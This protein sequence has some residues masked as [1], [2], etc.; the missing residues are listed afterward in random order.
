MTHDESISTSVSSTGSEPSIEALSDVELVRRI[1]GGCQESLLHL[2]VDRCG[3][4]LRAIA[5]RCHYDGDLAHD[6]C[7]HLFGQAGDWAKLSTWK[8]DAPLT[9]WIRS[10]AFNIC[11]NQSRRQLKYRARFGRLNEGVDPQDSGGNVADTLDAELTRSKLLKMIE[12]LDER[13]RMMILLHYLSHPPV[14]ID[15]LATMM[16]VKIETARVIKFRALERLRAICRDEGM[17]DV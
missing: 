11:F 4:L 10:V 9:A 6:V 12:K 14:P 8:G 3:G 15:Q 13:D 16:Q 7:V 5:A 1:V 2:V 17:H